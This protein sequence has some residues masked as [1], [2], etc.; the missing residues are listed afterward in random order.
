MRIRRCFHFLLFAGLLGVVPSAGS[1]HHQHAVG[2]VRGLGEVAFSTSCAVEVQ[3][4]FNGAVAMLHS[5]WYERSETA[6]AAV[7][8]KDPSCAMAYWGV[9]M[10]RFHQLWEK[11]SLED[12]RVGRASL[13]RARTVEATSE[14]ERGYINALEQFYKD[15]HEIDHL[16]RMMAYEGAMAELHQR[17]T[18][19]SE[20]AIFYALALLGTAYSAPPDQSL[21]RQKK[22]GA[23]LEKTFA[24]HT[25]HPGVAHYIIHSYDYPQLAGQA[26]EA[27][28]LYAK[29]APDAPHALHM[30]SHIFTRLG[31]W[32]ESI[33]SNRA[34]AAAAHKDQW[35]KEELHAMDYMVYAYLQGAQDGQAEKILGEAPK[36]AE[37]LRDNDHRYAVGAI[38]ARYALE[39]RQ[40]KE[41][42]G[43]AVPTDVFRGGRFC[44]AEATLHFARGLGAVHTGALADARHSIAQLEHCTEVLRY[45][46][47]S[48]NGDHAGGGRLN[49]KIWANLV[50]AQR[51]AVAAW[52]TLVEGKENEALAIMRSAANLEDSTDKPPTTPGAI[53]PARELLGE[54]LL[55]L[56]RPAEALP[57]FEAVLR[58]APNRFRSLYGAAR[59]A[60][61][62]G[63][64]EKASE[65]YSKLLELCRLADTERD[66]LRQ[67]KNFLK[68]HQRRQVN[69]QR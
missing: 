30:P 3:E 33:S 49:E 10:S 31:L 40:W 29:I 28:Q 27:A 11:P 66:E 14:R 53:V 4:D 56:E 37:K 2:D 16:S 9:A 62:A 44:W 8:Q 24:A 20:A 61:L 6:F 63:D 47:Q 67:A 5:F 41:A 18:D 57:E 38:P 42:A 25:N 48:N 19:D 17:Y 13:E 45:S 55:E 68:Q 7:A 52:L 60:E 43:L 35:A 22:A 58:D 50:D 1:Q 26:L 54:M 36:V 15:E 21:A 51:R 64:V 12:V 65:H 32:Q 46:G 69:E 23:I 34:A 59:A 39:N